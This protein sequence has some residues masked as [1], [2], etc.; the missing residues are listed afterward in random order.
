[1][2]SK[3][4][5]LRV[6]IDEYRL[7]FGLVQYSPTA[8]TLGLTFDFL[9]AWLDGLKD[10]HVIGTRFVTANNIFLLFGCRVLDLDQNVL[11]FTLRV[12]VYVGD[13]IQS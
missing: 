10:I 1:M 13:L 7:G 3:T 12:Y 4:V 2:I 6:T 9:Y 5:T 11:K 8:N